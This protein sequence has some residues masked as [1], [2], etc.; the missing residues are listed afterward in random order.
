MFK[1]YL[2]LALHNLRRN[3]VLTA[4]T[5][6]AIGV[7]I[8]ASMTV[9]TVLRAMSS[10]PIPAKSSQLFVPQIDNWTPED[11][12]SS[13]QLADGLLD[14]L[15][16]RDALALMQAHQGLRQTATYSVGFTVTPTA[17][18]ARPF[19]AI[20]RAAY[21]S[22]FPMFDVPFSAGG[23]W[24]AADDQG[25]ANVVVLGAKIAEKLFPAGHA[26]GQ[27]VNLD[28]RE[29]RVVG[30]LRHWEPEP[31]FYDVSSGSYLETEDIFLPF[32]TAIDRQMAS[33]GNNNCD[34]ESAPG[35]IGHLNSE[36]VWIG[37]WVELPTAAAVKH[38]REF[39]YNYAAEQRSVGRFHW[40]PRVN[41]QNVR[42]WLVSEKVVPDEMRISTLVAFGFLLVCLVNSVGLMLAKYTSRAGELGVRRAL[43]ASKADLFLQCLVET[44][45]V[46]ALGGLAGLALTAIG[47]GVERA[48]LSTDI[49]RLA[50]LN[51]GMVAI[52]LTLA[53][54]ATVCSGL[55]P[56]WRASRVEPAWQLKSQ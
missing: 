21:S 22:F 18:G 12:N 9:F 41:L 11:L 3:T 16:Y 26:V 28:Q 23:A 42:E 10:D 5:V 32:T 43:G 35:W 51:A 45:V 31:R 19:A 4:L 14:A 52:T 17:A 30:V 47:L 20:G 50:H 6:A 56:T 1:Y 24:S 40:A 54:L 39:L 49:A 36:C 27:T 34:A 46:G 53:V 33:Y 7:G 55:Y 13:P 38:Y 29:Y 25:R 15:T 37:F 44:A 48:I 8:G 2:G